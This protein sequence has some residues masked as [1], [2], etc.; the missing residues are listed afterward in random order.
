MLESEQHLLLQEPATTF[1]IAMELLELHS[2]ESI[3]K[4]QFVEQQCQCSRTWVLVVHND[5]LQIED[6]ERNGDEQDLENL[7]RVFEDERH[8][9]FAELA[10]CDKEQILG[11]LSSTEKLIKLF[12]PN[13]DCKFLTPIYFH[14]CIIFLNNAHAQMMKIAPHQSS[15]ICSFCRTG[16]L[17]AKF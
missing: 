4:I 2:L 6:Y 16:S 14:F 17:V 8:C 11:T 7:R 3:N 13:D 10:N 9:R 1:I 15:C 5:F 12:H